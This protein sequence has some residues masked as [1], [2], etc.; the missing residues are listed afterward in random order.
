MT[1]YGEKLAAFASLEELVSALR[2]VAYAIAD[3]DRRN[4]CH[5]D[6]SWGN[7]VL[8]PDPD[9]PD[10]LRRGYL[11]DFGKSIIGRPSAGSVPSGTS[12]F[13][14]VDVLRALGDDLNIR[15]RAHHDLESLFYVLCWVCTICSGP[16]RTYNH[17]LEDT[18]VDSWVGGNPLEP[19]MSRLLSTDKY[20][21]L[22]YDFWF[23]RNV[24]AHIQ[25]YFADLIP[26]IRELC[27]PFMHGERNAYKAMVKPENGENYVW[28][29]KVDED[30]VDKVLKVWDDALAM[31]RQK[32]PKSDTPDAAMDIK[33]SVKTS[34]E[35]SGDVSGAVEQLDVE[36]VE[37]NNIAIGEDRTTA[38]EEGLISEGLV[39][40][41]DD[42]TLCGGLSHEAVK[43]DSDSESSKTRAGSEPAH[44]CEDCNQMDIAKREVL[45]VPRTKRKREFDE[46]SVDSDVE[47]D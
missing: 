3:L 23:E 34:N 39:T 14:S 47:S 7:I 28:D 42:A 26:C 24:I 5:G 41:G 17:C 2:D 35:D 40:S 19:E 29:F 4:I 20:L 13:M 21:L 46:V 37:E 30:I 8:A 10:G 31:I 1:P 15:H 9:N 33:D 36:P 22:T 43:M 6:I 18:I 16:N 38:Q 11:I 32:V 27:K 12:C 25:P 45:S 44:K